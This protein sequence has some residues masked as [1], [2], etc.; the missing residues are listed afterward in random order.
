[1][2]KLK[3]L[4]KSTSYFFLAAAVLLC[5]SCSVKPTYTR[6]NISE[7]IKKLCKNEYDIDVT[8]WDKKNTI[9]IFAPIDLIDAN[10]KINQTKDGH[11]NEDVIRKMQ[12]ISTSINRVFLSSDQRPDFYCL[13][14]SSTKNT[15][16][17]W[18]LIT[19]IP[20]E[21]NYSLQQRNIPLLSS[22]IL[23]KKVPSFVNYTPLA[24]NDLSGEHIH[25]YDIDITEFLEILTELSLT[26]ALLKNTDNNK[27]ASSYEEQSVYSIS[28]IKANLS[29]QTFFLSFDVIQKKFSSEIPRVLEKVKETVEFIVKSYEPF[30]PIRKA[31]LTDVFNNNTETI[32]YSPKYTEHTFS[33]SQDLIENKYSL[34]KISRAA[35]FFNQGQI[36]LSEAKYDTVIEYCEKA[37]K[38]Y[39]EHILSKT[40]LGMAYCQLNEPDKALD[41]LEYVKQKA[42]NYSPVFYNIGL[43]Y[44]LKNDYEKAKDA[45]QEAIRLNDNDIFSY[46]QLALTYYNTGN[47]EPAREW[48]EKIINS[49]SPLII[50]YIKT[51]AYNILAETYSITNNN[52]MANEYYDKITVQ[53]AETIEEKN[54]LAKAYRKTGRLEKALET[55][56]EVLL[57]V[58]ENIV[59]KYGIAETYTLMSRTAEA[60]EKYKE[61]ALADPSQREY[62]YLAIA[63]IYYKTGDTENY[64]SNLG[65]TLLVNPDNMAANYALGQFYLHV[66]EY[67]KA[68]TFYEHIIKISPDIPD[69][70]YELGLVSFFENDLYKAKDL[71]LKAKDLFIKQGQ[72]EKAKKIDDA[73]KDIP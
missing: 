50:P 20:D 27:D 25:P 33:T 66:K 63:D 43:A 58:P 57:E 11:W 15:G 49:S 10:G 40:L 46:Y 13:I 60:I 19:F 56:N 55:Y 68:R 61:L 2:E 71:L 67:S 18:Y 14:Y 42:P 34:K 29:D 3:S 7:D 21:I 6:K 62:I 44:V 9:W 32:Y 48:A 59:A 64:V 54:T 52:E 45:F 65:Q 36:K 1:M 31:V 28:E 22:S 24:L 39:P 12:R 38:E 17:D 41:L 35:R 70:Y 37:L 51:N 26:N 30:Y 8:V 53:P 4:V 72:H 5:S 47:Y 16:I 73:L 23:F 69:V